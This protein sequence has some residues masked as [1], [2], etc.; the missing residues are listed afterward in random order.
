VRVVFWLLVLVLMLTGREKE[1][2]ETSSQ[3]FSFCGLWLKKAELGQ[4]GGR[5]IINHSFSQA[6]WKHRLEIKNC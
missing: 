1:M 4:E 5:E 3:V 6:D 2:E